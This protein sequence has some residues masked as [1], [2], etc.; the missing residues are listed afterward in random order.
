MSAARRDSRSGSALITVVAIFAF[1]S[2]LAISITSLT[3][4]RVSASGRQSARDQ[5]YLT[6]KSVMLATRDHLRKNPS[7][8]PLLAGKTASGELPSMG[9]YTASVSRQ[10]DGTIKI[11]V[12]AEFS[13]QHAMASGIVEVA[14]Q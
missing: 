12:E 3:L 1:V 4:A 11:T 10:S 7:D 14:Q 9:R 13:G 8:V 6:A 2:V 5:A